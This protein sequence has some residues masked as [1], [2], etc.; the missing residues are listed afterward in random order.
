MESTTSLEVVRNKQSLS[1][2]RI[3]TRDDRSSKQKLQ[4]PPASDFVPRA[5][6]AS[7]ALFDPRISTSPHGQTSK[8]VLLQNSHIQS[9]RGTT[10]NVPSG[11][12]LL[13]STEDSSPVPAQRGGILPASGLNLKG[14]NPGGL[15]KQIRTQKTEVR[16]A[17]PSEASTQMSDANDGE[18]NDDSNMVLQLKTPSISSEHLLTRIKGIYA[19]L[20]K[21]LVLCRFLQSEEL[22]WQCSNVVCF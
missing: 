4:H 12:T 13:P 9:S 7:R 15:R 18:T 21:C 17:S 8:S 16:I 3:L 14:L 22:P 2:P 5:K 20:R 6:V 10:S 1:T 11:E 19:G